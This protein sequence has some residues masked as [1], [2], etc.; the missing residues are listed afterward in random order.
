MS[1]KKRTVLIVDDEKPIVAQIFSYLKRQYSYEPIATANAA[2]VEKVLDTC[3]VEL[4]IAD[5]RMPN[6]SGFDII[7]MVQ[8]RNL[9]IP[10][11][12]ITAFLAQEYTK[13]QELGMTK[14]DVVEKPFTPEQLESRISSKLKIA[15]SLSK[16]LEEQVLVDN[17]AKV[18]IVDDEQE[19]AEIFATTLR[20]DDYEVTTFG[21]GAKALEHLKQHAK[22]YHVAVIDM[23]IPGLLGHE[24][25]KEL[26]ALNSKMEIIP[27]SARY[28]D[29]M[30]AHLRSVGFDPEKLVTKPFNLTELLDRIKEYAVKAGAYKEH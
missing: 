8:A 28:P 7:K 13:L 4:I 9:D 21:N 20:E 2:M 16:P 18:I 12:I 6:I 19:I 26:V 30:K 24:L 17:N 10:F 3:Q 25:I 1:E 22:D 11:V 15:P 29:T 5:L 14:D 23:A 27:I